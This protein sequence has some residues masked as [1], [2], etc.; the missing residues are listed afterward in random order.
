MLLHMFSTDFDGNI[1]CDDEN[2][3]TEVKSVESA[4]AFIAAD[5][6]NTA[7][8]EFLNNAL[9]MWF[10]NGKISM[11]HCGGGIYWNVEIV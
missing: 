6:V 8:D 10:A 4:T 9:R 3:F 7:S 5:L 2:T 11:L 1:Q